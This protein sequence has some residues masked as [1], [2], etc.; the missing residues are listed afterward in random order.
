MTTE[1]KISNLIDISG[2]W[3][4]KPIEATNS[5]LSSFY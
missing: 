3:F 4:K 5:K 2:I 1:D